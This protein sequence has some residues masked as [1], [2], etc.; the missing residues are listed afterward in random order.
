MEKLKKKK[1]RFQK[2]KKQRN[3]MRQRE[4][5]VDGWMDRANTARVPGYFGRSPDCCCF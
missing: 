1:S 2:R 5:R 4:Y 3:T